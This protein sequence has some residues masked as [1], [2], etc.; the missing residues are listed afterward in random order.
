MKT[1]FARSCTQSNVVRSEKLFINNCGYYFSITQNMKIE[2]P[3][4]RVDYHFIYVHRGML[5]TNFGKVKAGEYLYY[6]P[7]EPHEYE[8]AR[9]EKSAYFWVHYSGTD[10]A[11][12]LD[13][14]ESGIYS[15]EKNGAQIYELFLK[16]TNSI[17]EGFY[18]SEAYALGMFGA[19]CALICDEEKEKSPFGSVISMMHDL[20]VR[21]TVEDCAKRLK[22]SKEHFIR[23]FK[24]YTKRTP[25]S[26]RTDIMLSHAKNL[27]TETSFS[28]ST[29]AEMSGF[30]DA[31]YFSRVFKNR[32]GMS[33]TEFRKEM[34]I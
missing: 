10:A 14:R 1:V 4:G 23:S 16:M 3:L 12:L 22:M 34:T 29:V 6:K 24:S 18:K 19:I 17:Q 33:P 2:R 7:N 15:C 32:I 9:D 8:Y 28:V 21:Y 31:L 30:S 13:N 5:S 26:Y 11:E 25:L 20:S 27:L